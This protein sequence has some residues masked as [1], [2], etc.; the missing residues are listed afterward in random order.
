[1]YED[2][3]KSCRIVLPFCALVDLN[4]CLDEPFRLQESCNIWLC[5]DT[6]RL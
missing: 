4:N 5:H 1:V 2:L 3:C 6:P